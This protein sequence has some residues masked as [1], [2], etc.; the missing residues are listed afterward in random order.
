MSST[1]I[2]GH[3]RQGAAGDKKMN[4]NN[5]HPFKNPLLCARPCAKSAYVISLMADQ[6][7]C[8]KGTGGTW[9]LVLELGTRSQVP[10]S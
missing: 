5:G 7:S 1:N 2:Y 6:W 10:V 9:L 8:L 4:K 3:T